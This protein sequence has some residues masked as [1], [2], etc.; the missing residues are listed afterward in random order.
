MPGSS[1]D[2]TILIV[3][4][5][6][7]EFSAAQKG[8]RNHRP[9]LRIRLE[10]CG[11]G[12][13]RAQLY[14]EQLAPG[15]ISH[16]MLL[17]WAGGISPDLAAGDV[18]YASEARREGQPTLGCLKL[19]GLEKQIG[20]ILTVP[21]ALLRPDEKQ[22]ARS[23]GVKAVE[24]EAYPMADWAHRNNVPFIHVRVILDAWNESLP[25]F[26]KEIDPSG[27]VHWP[28]LFGRFAR[29]PDLLLDLWKLMQRIRAVDPIL[30]DQAEKVSSYL[31]I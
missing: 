28:Q 8:L 6:L 14:C 26:E 19:P 23:N 21:S 1:A 17:G 15:D 25:D 31:K 27:K 12:E 3:T 24:M 18:I 5:T 16:L 29:H 10:K 30:A 7:Q 22:A 9:E 4:P 2:S 11:V 13:K 20:P